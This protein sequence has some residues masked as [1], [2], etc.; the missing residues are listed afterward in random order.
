M[1]AVILAAGVGSRLQPYTTL[2]PKSLLPVGGK[3][4][5]TYIIERLEK[6]DLTEIIICVNEEHFPQ[7]KHELRDKNVIFS[8]SNK[9]LGTAGELLNCRHMLDEDFIIQ[10]GDE[11][12]NINYKRLIENYVKYKGFGTLAILSSFP[13][14]VGLVIT[15]KNSIKE[16]KEK[17]CL[18]INFWVGIGILNK[19][20]L[21]YINFGNDLA[22]DVF[23]RIIESGKKLYAEYFDCEW[24]DIGNI[25]RYK[26]AVSLAE[27]GLIS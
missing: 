27:K 6:L 22:K 12:T 25:S 9:P 16:F 19:N 24:I 15:K 8:T 20:I 13:L 7:F 14:P 17:H 10:Y 11:L 23:P 4:C 26:H 3:P 5:I 1:K 18:K 2:I 21:E